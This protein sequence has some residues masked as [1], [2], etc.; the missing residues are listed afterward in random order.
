MNRSPRVRATAAIAR[1]TTN[2]SA[3]DRDEEHQRQID[4]DHC[5]VPH[6]TDQAGQARADAEAAAGPSSSAAEQPDAQR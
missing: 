1:L 3:V 2:D 4:G 6:T 5:R